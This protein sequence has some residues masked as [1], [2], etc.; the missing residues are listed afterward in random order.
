MKT[1]SLRQTLCFL[2]SSEIC[3]SRSYKHL[4]PLREK[5]QEARIADALTE[6]PGPH[7]QGAH[8]SLCCTVVALKTSYSPSS[9]LLC[10]E[11]GVGPPSRAFCH[12]TCALELKGSG[13]QAQGAHVFLGEEKPRLSCNK[14]GNPHISTGLRAEHRGHR[15][16]TET[17]HPLLCT[18]APSWMDKSCWWAGLVACTG[19]LSPSC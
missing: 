3:L 6:C 2:G 7:S 11:W 19:H 8:L 17:Q 15:R 5:F 16:I 4:L 13:I 1:H 9:P 14:P 12:L 18:A 10:R